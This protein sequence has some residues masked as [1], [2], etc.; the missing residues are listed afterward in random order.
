VECEVGL[1]VDPDECVVALETEEGVVALETE[2]GVVGCEDW[3]L[4]LVVIIVAFVVIWEV[5]TEE[6][7]D[8][9]V[10]GTVV[11]TVVEGTAVVGTVVTTGTAVVGTVVIG[12]AVVGTAV[13]VDGSLEIVDGCIETV[14]GWMVV[15]LSLVELLPGVVVMPLPLTKLTAQ[16]ARSARARC[17][18]ELQRVKEDKNEC[19]H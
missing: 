9:C 7:D 12:T 5:G 16:S 8:M 1:T 6:V 3:E 18:L 14:D 17:I 2:E 15:E 13:V 10:V 19:L 4:L 11:G